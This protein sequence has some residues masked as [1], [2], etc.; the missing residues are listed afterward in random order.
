[1]KGRE[2]KFNPV[3]SQTIAQ[4]IAPPTEVVKPQPKR[5][6]ALVTPPIAPQPMTIPQAVKE[7]SLLDKF[8]VN[9]PSAPSI[10]GF[11]D[12]I[13]PSR[14]MGIAL[15]GGLSDLGAGIAGRQ[16]TGAQQIENNL[17][18]LK[19]NQIDAEETDPKSEKSKTTREFMQ[20]YYKDIG[21][22]L[23]INEN[24]SHRQ[25]VEISPFLDKRLNQFYAQRAASAKAAQP[26]D[27]TKESKDFRKLANDTELFKKTFEN[28]LDTVDKINPGGLGSAAQEEKAKLLKSDLALQLKSIAQ[29]GALDKATLDLVEDYIGT[30]DFTRKG[31]LDARREAMSDL[32]TNKLNSYRQQFEV[33]QI[34][35]KKTGKLLDV[36]QYGNILMEY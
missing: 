13:T 34:R 32:L 36:D 4:P 9:I 22:E 2:R 7:Q 35:D 15:A 33:Q 14:E 27:L 29:T 21:K 10:G 31:V 8:G 16:G 20:K 19:Q 1:M 26:K 18:A 12:A 30:P 3:A 11:L 28:Y 25:L 5:Q 17:K 24:M 23:P 6:A